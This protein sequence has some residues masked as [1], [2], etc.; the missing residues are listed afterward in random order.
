[1]IAAS[2][3]TKP[4]GA[5]L[6]DVGNGFP[7]RE[8]PSGLADGQRISTTDLQDVAACWHAPNYFAFSY[9]ARSGSI[10]LASFSIAALRL[11]SASF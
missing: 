10:F 4:S 11:S 5:I 1:M 3:G 7:D 2:Y 9:A 6:F 8:Q